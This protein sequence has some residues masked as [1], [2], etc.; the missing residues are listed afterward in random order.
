M[1]LETLF[2]IGDTIYF[3]EMDKICS[4][5]V[6]EISI[7]ITNLETLYGSKKDTQIFYKLKNRHSPV[8]ENKSFSSVSALTEHLKLM[9]ENKERK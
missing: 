9:F 4:S 6:E 8:N 2:N 1:K 7:G 5:I 3:L